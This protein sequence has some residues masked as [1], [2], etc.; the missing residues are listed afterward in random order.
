M[1]ERICILDFINGRVVVISAHAR[2]DADF[3]LACENAVFSWAEK[4][5]TTMNN[6]DWMVFTGEVQYQ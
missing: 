4:H 5:G 1:N 3:T 2:G 6:L